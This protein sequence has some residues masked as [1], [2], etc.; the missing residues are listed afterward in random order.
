MSVTF[1]RMKEN[2]LIAR[3]TKDSVAVA[4]LSSRISSEL[5]RRLPQLHREIDSLR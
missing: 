2:Y 4:L 1:Q 5:E 3:K